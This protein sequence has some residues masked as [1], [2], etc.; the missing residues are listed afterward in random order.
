MIPLCPRILKKV[1]PFGMTFLHLWLAEPVDTA[2][3]IPYSQ[4]S[5]KTVT[6]GN[7]VLK[8]WNMRWKESPDSEKD[9][10]CADQG[11]GRPGRQ[12]AELLLLKCFGLYP[13]GG[14]GSKEKDGDICPMGGYAQ[15]ARVGVVSHRNQNK[16]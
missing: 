12:A 11:K 4:S 16:A 7:G 9:T 13:K 8:K 15:Y 6:A 10:D 2:L 5:S 1:I 3:Q 14:G